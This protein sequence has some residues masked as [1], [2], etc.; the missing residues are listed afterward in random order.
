MVGDH[1]RTRARAVTILETRNVIAAIRHDVKTG[2]LETA[3]KHAAL[4]FDGAWGEA[5]PAQIETACRM[6]EGKLDEGGIR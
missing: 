3:R 1:H 6:V 2:N 5:G 4:V